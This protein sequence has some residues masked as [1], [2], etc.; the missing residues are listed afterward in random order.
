VRGQAE[1]GS[2]LD[3]YGGL[4]LHG[5]NV[6][7]ALLDEERRTVFAKRLPTI[8]NVLAPYREWLKSLAVESTFNW[9]WLVDGPQAH[10]YPAALANPA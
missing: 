6:Y 1:N 2:R 4:D 10:E 5:D 8:L 7:C 3:A 9:Y